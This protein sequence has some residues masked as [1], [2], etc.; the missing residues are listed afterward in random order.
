MMCN[1]LTFLGH[2]TSNYDYVDC[3]KH[4]LCY[5]TIPDNGKVGD[6]QERVR[7]IFTL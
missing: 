2:T 5:L 1:K 7:N 6:E 4:D 3:D